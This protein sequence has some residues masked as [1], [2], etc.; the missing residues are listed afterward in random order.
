[1]LRWWRCDVQLQSNGFDTR[2]LYLSD[3]MLSRV[4]SSRQLCDDDEDQRWR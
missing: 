4:R 2:D 1:M 3:A